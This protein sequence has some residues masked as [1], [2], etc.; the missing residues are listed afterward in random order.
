MKKTLLASSL[1][2]LFLVTGVLSAGAVDLG[3]APPDIQ[4]KDM[5]GKEFRL[6]DHKG[7]LIILKLATTW[8]PTCRQQS[9]E[10]HK[11]ADFLKEKNIRIVEVFL[12][13]SEKMVRDYLEQEKFDSPFDVMLD[14]GQA[15]AA[16]NVYLIP[17]VVLINQDYKVIRDGNILTGQ[18]IIAEFEKVQTK[19]PVAGER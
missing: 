2:L 16:Y 4:L 11:I 19:S 3:T 8:C 14:N 13:D 15:L 1:V 7:E 6:S 12:Q 18:Q 17:R 9:A 5:N 10:F